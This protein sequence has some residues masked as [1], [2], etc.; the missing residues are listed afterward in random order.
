MVSTVANQEYTVAKQTGVGTVANQEYTVAKQTGV[1][2]EWVELLAFEACSAHA[3]SK[4]L[5]WILTG[6][7]EL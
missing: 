4:V 2:A 6:Y 7:L 5:C 1:G 3:A